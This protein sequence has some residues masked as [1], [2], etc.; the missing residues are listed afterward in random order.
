M[1]QENTQVRDLKI[2]MLEIDDIVFCMKRMAAF[3]LQ[4][5]FKDSP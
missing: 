3:T 4:V 5:I 2:L 1:R